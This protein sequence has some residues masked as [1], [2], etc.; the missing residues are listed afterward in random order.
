MAS[1]V[2]DFAWPRIVEGMRVL[3]QRGPATAGTVWQEVLRRIPPTPSEVAVGGPNLQ[4]IRI[5]FQWFST[6][7]ARIGWISKPPGLGWEIT[8]AG[9]KALADF[10]DLNDLR[11]EDDRLYKEWLTHKPDDAERAWLIRPD[12]STADLI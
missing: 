4:K 9:L 1:A 5:R 2:N 11:E 8:N 7:L 12:T 3:A 10:P 6:G